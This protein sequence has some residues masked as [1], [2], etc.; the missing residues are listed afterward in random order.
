MRQLPRPSLVNR[1][2]THESLKKRGRMATGAGRR[3][4]ASCRPVTRN[5]QE[6]D[7][8]GGCVV[9]AAFGQG[10]PG[11]GRA[12]SL[13]LCGQPLCLTRA[14]DPRIGCGQ[15]VGCFPCTSDQPNTPPRLAAWRGGGGN[16]PTAR[17][18]QE[19]TSTENLKAGRRGGT[20]ARR[21]NAIKQIAPRAGPSPGGDGGC[22]PG[23]TPQVVV[24]PQPSILNLTIMGEK[25]GGLT[26]ANPLHAR[27]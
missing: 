16:S 1:K 11:K 15:G 3:G 27:P 25:K 12:A 23:C 9:L 2:T 14:G 10:Q 7:H 21:G 22:S 19:V 13:A 8:E 5:N 26:R 6:G 17:L 24:G 18:H 20:P 4:G